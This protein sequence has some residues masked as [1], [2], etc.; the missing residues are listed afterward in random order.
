MADAETHR[1]SHPTGGDSHLTHFSSAGH[2]AK[3]VKPSDLLR[4]RAHSRP[5]GPPATHTPQ[6]AERPIDR[7]ERR[8]LV[9]FQ[10]FFLLSNPRLVGLH[11]HTT[12]FEAS[13]H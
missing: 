7:D 9:S 11:N 6:R 1:V 12:Q 5:V 4:P 8:A 3:Y 10:S 2:E 13:L